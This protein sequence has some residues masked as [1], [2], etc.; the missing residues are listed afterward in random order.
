MSIIKDVRNKYTHSNTISIR[1]AEKAICYCHDFIDS[2]RMYYQTIGKEKD[3]NV[4]TFLR[5]TD[6]QG[7]THYFSSQTTLPGYK[8][9]LRSGDVYRVEVEIDPTFNPC[10]YKIEWIYEW[11]L[12]KSKKV[13]NQTSVD[14]PI[15]NAMVGRYLKIQCFIISNKD[16]HKHGW[17]D[18]SFDYLISTI[19]PPIEESY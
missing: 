7:M 3:Y 9:R 19:L 11:E 2:L 12:M 4:P 18:D 6:S 14:I 5:L 15:I 10:N 13:H 1:D 16:W 8:I 17:Y